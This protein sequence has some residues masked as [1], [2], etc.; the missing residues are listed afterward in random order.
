M[1][2]A[3]TCHDVADAHAA[4]AHRAADRES[5]DRAVEFDPVTHDPDRAVT[6]QACVLELGIQGRAGGVDVELRQ[7][8]P[9]QARQVRIQLSGTH[10]GLP[11]GQAAVEQP[12][13]IE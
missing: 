12:H 10:C 7:G 6:H 5:A 3:P 13:L 11:G 1:A 9:M 2:R 8:F 4:V